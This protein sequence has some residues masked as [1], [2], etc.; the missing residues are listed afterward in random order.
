MKNIKK[1]A[2]LAALFICI[3]SAY[4]AGTV[5]KITNGKINNVRVDA[6]GK[7]IIRFNKDILN[8][9]NC[10][11]EFYHSAFSFDVNTPGGQAI[12]SMALTAKAADK[13][14]MAY[15]TGNCSEYT[16]T[17]ESINMLIIQ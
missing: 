13:P 10:T 12:Y 17:V 6:N 4:A 7:G 3:N 1:F 14:I 5:S 15:G 8:I 2:I 9:A 16:N 11:E